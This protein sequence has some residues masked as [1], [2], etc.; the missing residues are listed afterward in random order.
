MA[1]AKLLGTRFIENA[2]TP[3]NGRVTPSIYNDD[4]QTRPRPPPFIL[5]PPRRARYT[6]VRDFGSFIPSRLDRLDA[7]LGLRPDVSDALL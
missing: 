3:A 2:S 5:A 7:R 6:L 4:E 1:L